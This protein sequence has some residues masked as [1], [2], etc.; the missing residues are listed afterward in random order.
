[1]NF[2]LLLLYIL[3]FN[4]F[5]LFA[6]DNVLVAIPLPYTYEFYDGYM[7]GSGSCSTCAITSLRDPFVYFTS[8]PDSI[9]VNEPLHINADELSVTM[10][11]NK[12]LTFTGA[13]GKIDQCVIDINQKSSNLIFAK[14]MT[15]YCEEY[16]NLQTV[17][18]HLGESFILGN[19]NSQNLENYSYSQ[20]L[21]A[22]K[23][24]LIPNI[25]IEKDINSNASYCKPLF[26]RTGI[27]IVD[28]H[29]E[30]L[31]DNIEDGWQHINDMDMRSI[32]P[33]SVSPQILE[34]ALNKDL[35]ASKFL[36]LRFVLKAS[37]GGKYSRIRNSNQDIE[38]QSLNSGTFI[39]GPYSFYINRCAPNLD[40]SIQP[41]PQVL[42]PS[43]K[44]SKN[45]SFRLSFDRELIVGNG[46]KLL[47]GLEKFTD[48]SWA[49]VKSYSFTNEDYKD[50][51]ITWPKE[52]SEGLYRVYW[53]SLFES[54][55]DSAIPTD[56]NYS[57]PFHISDPELLDLKI[58][59]SDVKCKNE[60][61]GRITCLP[62]GGIPPYLLSINDG[63]W[64]S[65]T[66]FK[67]LTVGNYKVVL[68]DANGCEK[69]VI[70]VINEPEKRLNVSLF[71]I[72]NPKSNSS[73]DGSIDIKITGSIGN[74]SIEWLK[75]GVIF[76]NEQ[77]INQLGAGIY[78]LTVTDENG[79]RA[80]T[81]EV[82]IIPP[83]V[84][85]VDFQAGLNPL[86]CFGELTSIK[87]QGIGGV[88]Q[89]D[90]SYTYLWDDGTVNQERFNL[91]AGSYSVTVKDK[92]GVEA[93]DSIVIT[94]PKPFKVNESHT[95]VSCKYGNNGT[96]ELDIKGG[97]QPYTIT[98]SK[99][100]NPNFFDEGEII[101]GL[102]SGLYFYEITD[103]NNC[104]FNNFS[105]GI[106]I[107]EPTRELGVHEVKDRH[108]DNIIYN[109]RSGV[110]FFEFSGT[111][112]INKAIL[113]RDKIE[114]IILNSTDKL[115]FEGLQAGSYSLI[116]FDDNGCQA[117]LLQEAIIQEPDPLVL[118]HFIVNNVKCN[119]DRSGEVE[120]IM[121]G[122][123]PPYNFQVFDING[124][125]LFDTFNNLIDNLF[126][127][128]YILKIVDSSKSEVFIEQPFQVFEPSNLTLTFEKGDNF[129]YGNN[130]G[131]INL[132]A[133][134]GTPPYSYSWN[135]GEETGNVRNL[136]SG[137]YSVVISDSL[138]CQIKKD[139]LIDQPK[140]I[141]AIEN[142]EIQ[143]VSSNGKADGNI[144]IRVFGGTQPYNFYWTG[145][146]MFEAV[147]KDIENLKAGIY[148][149]EVM[150][151]VSS[152][153]CL[154]DVDYEITEP[155][156]LILELQTVFEPVCNGESEGELL[157]L[158]SGGVP[159]YK[160]QW[161]KMEDS[162]YIKLIQD[163]I[164]AV[165]LTSGVYMAEVTDMNG[166][167]V[168]S[169]VEV[170]G[171]EPLEIVDIKIYPPLCFND[172]SGGISLDISGGTKPYSIDWNNGMVGN[173]IDN[174]IAGTYKVQVTDANGCY[175]DREIELIQY[176]SPISLGFLEVAYAST[177]EGKDGSITLSITGGV[178]PYKLKASNLEYML[179]QAEIFKL[180]D[181]Q[182]GKYT[183]EITDDVGCVNTQ[184]VIIDQPDLVNFE[185]TNSGCSGDCQGA[186]SLEVNN[187]VSDYIY[188][189][190]NGKIG[191]KIQNL[192]PGKYTVEILRANKPSIFRT[193]EIPEPI[194][195]EL[196]LPDEVVVC[197]D[198][199][200][201]LD[202]TCSGQEVSYHWTKDAVFYSDQA[203]IEVN[204]NGV[205][206]LR[207]IVDGCEAEDRVMVSTSQQ[208]VVADFLISSRVYEDLPVYA[209]DISIPIPEEAEWRVPEGVL[210]KSEFSGMAEL[211]FPEPGT[212]T[213]GLL[214]TIDGCTALKSKEVIV[215]DDSTDPSRTNDSASGKIFEEVVI[216]PN[217]GNGVFHLK[218][219]LY[220]SS[221]LNVKVYNLTS[222]LAVYSNSY[223][224]TRHHNIKTDLSNQPP[225]IYALCLET[226]DGNLVRKLV[227]N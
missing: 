101:K 11:E 169:Q 8:Y 15:E 22:M 51:N 96:I 110:L 52:I 77:N 183:I 18:I 4:C 53:S 196:D 223:L 9:F 211:V 222:N 62:I 227:I 213:I 217:P 140:E 119:E 106:S 146:N 90:D 30:Y 56:T 207:V 50:K 97:I 26:N 13:D 31:T 204:D 176:N 61:T 38:N 82:E 124:N 181:L 105:T 7:D 87:A 177:F 216:Y 180:H 132:N 159:P 47:I 49:Y 175:L 147:T 108:E 203:V 84:L 224:E 19:S 143:N 43:C 81:L 91:K 20:A 35:M 215:L 41:N 162:S 92:N 10:Y 138:G 137:L 167:T 59:K 60:A 2:K 153:G 37:G 184:E 57:T 148:H 157:A 127:G 58:I 145:P 170:K 89:N 205:Y 80:D 219:D 70:V 17:D 27:N 202:G 187:G 174:L 206:K 28:G 168:G 78:E 29:W 188:R 67:E 155:E 116:I 54:E 109:G 201:T 107:Y 172:K 44:G 48:N 16:I 221:P 128:K 185:I 163:G 69:S 3:A 189:W 126:A 225:G 76:S 24:W 149:L 209:V 134:G 144:K 121:T 136:Y 33:L 86:N 93:V 1:M 210:L 55:G 133:S 88:S 40:N 36:K 65:D 173:K 164:S 118:D 63:E 6:Q 95:N 64:V 154:L 21:S 39:L 111:Q 150:D 182:A 45:G 103:F 12:N 94:E 178:P 68:K 79:C 130:N 141:L 74:Y 117:E 14:T 212:Y 179:Q 156:S 195:I 72:M 152:G 85:K 131:W 214:T 191:S 23:I 115:F 100:L 32:Y 83:P 104:T 71:N 135:T 5:Y 113:Y 142:V 194:A 98:W 158:I 220:R 161:Y 208:E 192:C 125:L 112:K 122:G 160:I 193:Y 123:I 166:I 46:E 165:N 197:K 25:D 75:N 151:N 171:V 218:A 139:I 99:A 226:L 186:I 120:V 129:C 200:I 42:N 190:N 199:S 198:R 73:E 34:K 66:E 114:H 102:S